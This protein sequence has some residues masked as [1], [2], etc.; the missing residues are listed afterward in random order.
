MHMT[1]YAKTLSKRRA[2]VA[3]WELTQKPRVWKG[4]G[5][6]LLIA[7]L[8]LITY[9]AV[10]ATLYFTARLIIA[11]DAGW[12][13]WTVGSLVALVVS[14]VLGI[15]LSATTKC[16]LCHGTPLMGNKCRK[17]TLANKLPLLTYRASSIVHLI[18]T[19]KFR[20]MFCST[21]YRLGRR[22]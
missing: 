12:Q 18:F 3:D 9:A 4:Q 13:I 15:L 6:L 7:L 2:H 22:A 21:P 10:P 17:H 14:L 5:R 20:C 16:T 8:A 11:P 1:R 19:G